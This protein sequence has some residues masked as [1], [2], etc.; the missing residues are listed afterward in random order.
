MLM[1]NIAGI[2]LFVTIDGEIRLDI[3][4]FEDFVFDPG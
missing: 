3:C 1:D 2:D 4:R